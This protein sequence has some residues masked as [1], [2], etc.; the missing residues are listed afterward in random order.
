MYIYYTAAHNHRWSP[1]RPVLRAQHPAS[2]PSSKQP[3]P[4]CSLCMESVSATSRTSSGPEQP[5]L[6]PAAVRDT[7]VTNAGAANFSRIKTTPLRF[8]VLF[9]YACLAIV[10]AIGWNIFAPVAKKAYLAYPSW[11]DSVLQWAV[12][13]ANIACMLN[14]IP[15]SVSITRCGPR[16]VTLACATCC[17]TTFCPYMRP[18]IPAGFFWVGT[19]KKVCVC[20]CVCV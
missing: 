15:T 13:I 10:Q 6:V 3:T 9:L 20:V 1:T 8:L 11:N 16:R 18:L 14:M 4:R 5:L 2:S 7:D 12:N 19:P 17:L